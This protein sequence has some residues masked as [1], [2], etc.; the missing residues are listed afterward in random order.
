M[1]ARGKRE[2]FSKRL[3]K[4][5]LHVCTCSQ[6]FPKRLSRPEFPA[7][8]TIAAASIDHAFQHKSDPP[9]RQE[10][11]ISLLATFTIASYPT[12]RPFWRSPGSSCGYEP[13]GSSASRRGAS[14]EEDGKLIVVSTVLDGPAYHA[15]LDREDV[16]LELAG[17]PITD[18]KSLIEAMKVFAPSDSATIVFEKRGER[19]EAELVFEQNPHIEVVPF[20]KASK[21]VTLEIESFRRAWLGSS[22]SHALERHCHEC[23]RSFAFENAFCPYDGKRL[24]IVPKQ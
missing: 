5:P 11:Q 12:T 18:A 23:G 22:L 2:A 16:I 6:P 13:K 21:D 7:F 24:K 17:R 14:A 15:G 9:K 4:T 20:E 1:G 8:S 3:W 19:R 10:N